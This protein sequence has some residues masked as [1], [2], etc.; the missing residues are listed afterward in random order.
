MRRLK[1]FKYC[2]NYQPMTQRHKKEQIAAGKSGANRFALF[3]VATNLQL[4]K[5][6]VSMKCNK[7]Q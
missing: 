1:I 6:S 5:N 7:V 4:I 3:K 2:K